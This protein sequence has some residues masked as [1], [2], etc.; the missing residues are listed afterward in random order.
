MQTRYRW[1][2]VLLGTA[3]L[4][5]TNNL[6]GQDGPSD[7]EGIGAFPYTDDG[8]PG[9]TFRTWAPNADSVN[10]AGPFN[11]WNS[12]NRPLFDEGNGYWSVDVPFVQAGSLYQFVIRN[13]GQELWRNDPCAFDVTNS[14]GTSRVYDPDAYQWQTGEF[15]APT[16]NDLVIYELHLGTFGPEAGA[17][18]NG[19]LQMAIDRLDYL[20]DLGITAIELMPVM[21]FPGDRSWGYNP[22]HI[23]AVESSHG[24]EDDL[25][26]FVDEAHQRGI[27]V[28]CDLVYSHL[29]PNDIPTWQYDGW[30]ENGRGGIY[31][32]NDDRANTPWGDTRPDFGRE[33]VRN[34]LKSNIDYW[35]DE[36]RF[37]GIRMDGTKYIRYAEP[38]NWSLPEGWSFLQWV[39]NEGDANHT[40]KIFIAEDMDRNDWITR[41][42]S[43]GGAGFDSQ[44]DP[45]FFWPIRLAVETPFDQDRDM[46]QVRDAIANVYNG[47]H[48]NRVIYTESHDEVANGSSRV[49]EEIWPGNADSWFSKKR[50]TL[51][52]ALVFTS[53]GIPMMFQGQELLEDEWFRDEVSQ[54]WNRLQEF[55]GIHRLYRRLIE[56]RTNRTG[57]TQGLRGANTNVFHVNN[58]DKMIAFHRWDQGGPGDD[59]VVMANFSNT[60]WEDYRIG[61]PQGGDWKLL[62]NSDADEY[63]PDF[64]NVPGYDVYGEETPYDG[65]SHSAVVPI[66]PYS[67]L[68]YTQGEEIPQGIPG[69]YDGNGAVD[70]ADLTVLLGAWNAIDPTIDLDGDN[71]ITGSDLAILLGNWS[72]DEG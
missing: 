19:T 68:I 42:T 60:T 15:E 20:E 44:W 43:S 62:F 66:G 57:A 30:N 67:V 27:A 51:A 31:F 70:G 21:E 56:L 16:W 37:D 4:P 8:S 49:P 11:F 5:G 52:G 41:P 55:A 69:D 35:L 32:Y 17:P 63:D 3:L 23:Y 71:R 54:D 1:L 47:I 14:A 25:K 46:W 38:P 18:A 22:S 34:W 39:N 64:D 13:D 59:V 36:F 72:T 45:G 6:L 24:S 7:R 58:D 50:S 9:V 10:V 33:E 12:T 29:G 65:L 28:L 61:L 40:G 53:P 2:L 26:R 48:T